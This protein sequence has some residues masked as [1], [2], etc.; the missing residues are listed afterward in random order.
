MRRRTQVARLLL[1]L[2]ILRTCNR[3]L[4]MSSV[5]YAIVF[6]GQIV[7]GFQLI[8]VKAH[9]AKLLKA[10][11][12]KMAVLFSG[13]PVVIKRTADKQEALKYGTALK[14][15]GADVKIKAFKREAP[16]AKPAPP[17]TPD[18]ASSWTLAPNEG[19]LVEPKPSPPPPQIDTSSLKLAENDGAPLAPPKPVAPINLD[20][21]EYTISEMNGAP[22]VAPS[23]PAPKIDAPDF[24]LDAPGAVLETLKEEKPIVHPDT[25]GLTLA[26]PGSNLIDA[27]EK[28]R[29]P[30]PRVPDTSN[31]QLA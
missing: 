16:V 5:T 25:S 11:V 18:D 15:V 21:S 13:K 30:P 9:L 14:R 10:D 23:T 7:D 22:L 29:T 12:D 26:E 31:I 3:Y 17:P 27:D 8:S 4:C 24:G 6:S 20:L 1:F 28:P 2:Y 19:Y